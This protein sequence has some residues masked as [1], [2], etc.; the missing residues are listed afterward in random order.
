M[1]TADG[2]RHHFRACH[3]CEALCGVD[4]AV[5]G[6]Q[7][8]SVRGDPADAFSRGHICPKGVALQDLHH[9]PD[10]LRH[11]LRRTAT[12]WE[13]IGWRQAFDEAGARLRE[14]Q[15]R[16]GRDA[17][18]V[19]FGN[20][21]A[22]NYG[23]LLFLLPFLK[24]L[25][26]RNRFSASSLDQLPHSLA[27][28]LM[29]GHPFLFPVP[30]L[31]RT[32]HLV[33]QGANP[34]ASNG[35]LM[36]APD[37]KNRLRELRARGGRV[38]VIDPRRNETAELADR[39]VFIRPGTDAVL[40]LAVLYTLDA[41]GLVQ[42]GRLRPLID[43]WDEF[44][45][46]V[47]G[48]SPEAAGPITGID[49]ETIRL[50][51]RQF[52]AAPSASWY[53]RVGVCHQEFAGLAAWL[54]NALNVVVGRL[55]HPGG[56][57]FPRPPIDPVGSGLAP[58]GGFAR[59]HSRVRGLPEFDGEL[60][61]VA[62]AEEMTTP[63]PGQI[64]ALV[65]CAGN[66]VLSAPNGR[67]LEAALSGLEFMVAV[68]P[69][70][71]ETTRHAHLI[72]PPTGGLEHEHFDLVYHLVAIRNTVRLSP[73]VFEPAADTRHDWEIL[74]E[75]QTRVQSRGPI[76]G[77]LARVYRSVLRGLG[78]TGLLDLLLRFGPYG[79]GLRFWR[80]GLT[81]RELRKHPHGLD[82]GPLEPCLP[83]RLA[84]RPKR[85]RLAPE[86]MLADLVR[87]RARFFPGGVPTAPRPGLVLI[88]RRDL[89]SNNSWMHNSERLVRGK[90]RCTLLMHPADAASRGISDGQLVRVTSRVGAVEVPVE[91]SDAVMPGVVS[92]P[93]GWGH[94]RD[95]TLLRTA[96]AHPGASANDITDE[97][98]IDALSGTAAFNGLP[99][100]VVRVADL[101]PAS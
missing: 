32:H 30:D 96:Q 23:A 6:E 92:L 78:P 62:L 39:H 10:R 3:L 90:H 41:E 68:D 52:A 86:P 15:R 11:P 48:V 65:V 57:M 4:I 19:Y 37:V 89:R 74:L 7:I 14:I 25:G 95:G 13:Q 55:D 21:Y 17:V 45:Q 87:L 79:S 85:I 8:V 83:E 35:S 77:V 99:V 24:A 81:L 50:L 46:A 40:L 73:A 80:R 91:L 9:D 72:L 88:G 16:Q 31:E 69:Y 12:G 44:W 26:T 27:S 43:G 75:L 58:F 100:E 36:T 28:A 98:A 59:W 82:L 34:A 84:T 70:V 5:E 60:P 51:A 101:T 22:H 94:T 54:V 29:F 2:V 49:P 53:G 33:I 42:P 66:P 64:R 76:S 61:A 63:G 93:H 38:V 1:S 20:P 56:A 18:A 97:L 67:R 71:N 47:R